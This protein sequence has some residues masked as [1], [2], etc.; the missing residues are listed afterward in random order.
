MNRSNSSPAHLVAPTAAA[1]AA[2]SASAVTSSAITQ[3]TH[4]FS[5]WVLER[6]LSRNPQRRAEQRRLRLSLA[7]VATLLMLAGLILLADPGAA[8]PQLGLDPG[9]AP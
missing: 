9:L 8:P 3:A 2:A 7:T 6:R 5:D 1:R 4:P